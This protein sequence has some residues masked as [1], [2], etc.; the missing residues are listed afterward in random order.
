MEQMVRRGTMK[1]IA[2]AMLL[3]MK[4]SV[5]G[6]DLPYPF[7]L[8]RFTFSFFGNAAKSMSTFWCNT[9]GLNFFVHTLLE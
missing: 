2:I 5:P 9:T 6:P 3:Y 1:T 8:T 4:S 7:Y